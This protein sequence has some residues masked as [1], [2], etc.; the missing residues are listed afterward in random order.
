[1]LKESLI[2]LQMYLITWYS[3]PTVK[4]NWNKATSTRATSNFE[5]INN[6]LQLTPFLC[7]DIS[8]LNCMICM[9]DVY[10]VICAMAHT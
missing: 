1:M 4:I 7:D 2:I 5:S 9:R 10:E 6:L 8:L 3:P